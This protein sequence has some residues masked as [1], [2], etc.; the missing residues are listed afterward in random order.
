MST[1]DDLKKAGEITGVIASV[2]LVALEI[3]GSGGEKDKKK[4]KNR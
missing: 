3:L 1:N 2:F 4:G